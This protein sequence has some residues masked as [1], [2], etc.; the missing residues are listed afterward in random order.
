VVVA[1]EHQTLVL[2]LVLVEVQVHQTLVL[3]RQVRQ[4]QEL[5]WVVLCHHCWHR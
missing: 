3:V 5:V 2:V 1:P 4:K